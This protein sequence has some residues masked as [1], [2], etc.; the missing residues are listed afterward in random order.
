VDVEVIPQVTWSWK[1]SR[2]QTALVGLHLEVDH[3]VVVEIRAGGEA[4][5]AVDTFEGLF[6]AVD[7]FVGVQGA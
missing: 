4:F 5:A 7:S 2:T 3:F 1:T 6:T